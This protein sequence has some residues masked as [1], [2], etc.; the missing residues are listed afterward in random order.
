[1][2]IVVF[3]CATIEEKGGGD[4]EDTDDEE[5]LEGWTTQAKRRR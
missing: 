3:S 4:E 2:W 5:D 1:V